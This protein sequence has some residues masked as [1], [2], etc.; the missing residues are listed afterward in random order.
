MSVCC[1]S[2]P[3]CMSFDVET[4]G[5]RQKQSHWSIDS[6][7]LLAWQIIYSKQADT[8][9]TN[10]FIWGMC[11]C[12]LTK[13][14]QQRRNFA[15][16]PSLLCFPWGGLG[17]S[18]RGGE[19]VKQLVRVAVCIQRPK[20]T[21]LS[22]VCMCVYTSPHSPCHRSLTTSITQVWSWME[23]EGSGGKVEQSQSSCF[24]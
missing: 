4:P 2:M 12:V 6:E 7:A 9:C 18:E 1:N 8:P 15:P 17:S 5:L 3:V 13:S 14:Q 21:V 23:G 20:A 11:A 19:V 22:C 10:S 24:H 16:P